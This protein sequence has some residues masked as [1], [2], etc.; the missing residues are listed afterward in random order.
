MHVI[1]T[2]VQNMM[3]VDRNIMNYYFRVIFEILN[4]LNTFSI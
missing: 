1:C 4:V 3:F 2:D